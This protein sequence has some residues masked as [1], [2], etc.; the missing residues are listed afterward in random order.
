MNPSAITSVRDLEIDLKHIYQMVEGKWSGNWQSSD[1]KPGGEIS[2][3]FAV[4]DK[5]GG[6]SSLVPQNVTLTGSGCEEVFPDA[7][8]VDVNNG[9]FSARRKDGAEIE[10]E[11]QVTEGLDAMGGILRYEAGACAGLEGVFT[12]FKL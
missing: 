9:S 10:F 5:K 12:M 11:F 6:I 3:D 7:D 4:V 8:P 2:I 1:G